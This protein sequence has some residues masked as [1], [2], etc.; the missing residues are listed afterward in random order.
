MKKNPQLP[1]FSQQVEEAYYAQLDLQVR[2]S[3]AMF[4]LCAGRERCQPHYHV[5]R[6]EYMTYGLEFVAEGTGVLK[7]QGR[8]YPLFPGTMFLYGPGISHIISS[9][10]QHP[11][12][13]YFVDFWGKDSASLFQRKGLNPGKVVQILELESIRHLFEELIR[14]GR[15]SGKNVAR[16]VCH[17]LRII[18]L[19][20]FES[21]PAL[22]RPFS[23]TEQTFMRCQALI[24]K[25]FV[26]LRGLKELACAA[27]LDPS[28]LC[29]LYQRFH[30]CTPLECLTRRKLQRAAELLSMRPMMIKEVASMVGYDDPLH[31]SR[32]FRQHF[33]CSP[34]D[35]QKN[36][37]FIL[38]AEK[39]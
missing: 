37:R 32:L 33:S 35:F 5:Q 16:M 12:V 17:Y 23:V 38:P 27:G 1:A 39:K 26:A 22:L 28:Y 2:S 14:E 13:K 19:K 29:R 8:K 18:M 30:Q 9:S 10:T 7:L 6:P 15:K 24:E 4:V 34:R 25:E 20:S 11:M 3:R 21:Q 31:F 36:H